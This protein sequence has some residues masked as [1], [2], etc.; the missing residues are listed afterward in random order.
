MKKLL[1]TLICVSLLC[2]AGSTYAAETTEKA[3]DIDKA[4]YEYMLKNEYS[5]FKADLNEDGII[6]EN[7]LVS[8]K[9]VFLDL[10]GVKDISWLKRMTSLQNLTLKSG[11]ITDFS[12][13]TEMKS[14]KSLYFMEVPVSDINFVKDMDLD[15][16]SIYPDY[17]ITPDKLFDLIKWNDCQVN[18][19]YTAYAGGKPDNIINSVYGEKNG[20]EFKVEDT[21]IAEIAL[22]ISYPWYYASAIIYGKKA[23]TTTYT[24]ECGGE[25]VH[26]GTI[27]VLPSEE[28]FD[29]PKEFLTYIDVVRNYP[30]AKI[31]WRG[32]LFELKGAGLVKT[33]KDVSCVGYV[34]YKG[35][36]INNEAYTVIYNDGRISVNGQFLELD[37]IRM[38]RI[39]GSFLMDDKGN[40]YM[41]QMTENGDFTVV[42][43]G[44][45]F[46]CSIEGSDTAY[47][48][49]TGKVVYVDKETMKSYKTT[50]GT[51]ISAMGHYF[52]DEDNIL[53]NA[54]LKNNSVSVIKIAENVESVGYKRYD[55]NRYGPVFTDTNGDSYTLDD[56]K[57]VIPVIESKP[58]LKAGI[59]VTEN[60]LTGSQV[61]SSEKDLYD[62]IISCDNVVYIRNEDKH[63]SMTGVI[64][65][66]G[67]CGED[68]VKKA[69]F[70]RED[71]NIWEFDAETNEFTKVDLS[72]IGEA[73]SGDLNGDSV[74]DERD[75]E[76]LSQFIMN[77][78]SKIKAEDLNGDG[79]INT[80]DL[81]TLRQMIAEG[82]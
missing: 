71:Y 66:L 62:Y 7:E 21:D 31:L 45:N 81:V 77:P 54:V 12:F 48:D 68:K 50:I 27:T 46:E 60:I 32:N 11:D 58:Y 33:D 73:V 19:G 20:I 5:D 3:A 28:T 52:V 51:P 35:K 78:F 16:F 23:G 69:Y 76:Q 14:L 2:S 1:S 22:P 18:V 34:K 44:S 43:V 6:S 42:K 80:F 15:E 38:V 13:L 39:D 47:L 36:E 65:Y 37:D 79:K 72:A 4:A 9:S 40:S 24:V 61:L 17:D 41:H 25:T 29:P 74:L 55:T 26:T 49:R 63:I 8:L 10:T 82:Q 67:C 56:K 53:W 30:E 64:D 57:K 70:I 75:L 59:F